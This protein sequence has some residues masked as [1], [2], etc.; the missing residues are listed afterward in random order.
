MDNN[1]KDRTIFETWRTSAELAQFVL[2]QEGLYNLDDWGG[3]ESIYG[4]LPEN[5]LENF[6]MIQPDLVDTIIK[7][8]NRPAASA[9]VNNLKDYV[10]FLLKELDAGKPLAYN[11]FAISVEIC[12]AMGIT[13]LCYEFICG[14][15]AA[16]YVNGCEEGIDRIEAEGYPD[17]LCSTQKGTAGFLL[18]G[19]IPKPDVLI[20]PMTP[21]DAS[22]MLYGW[23]SQKL[24]IPLIPIETPYYRDER[25]LKYLVDDIKRMIERLEKLTGNTLDEDKLREYVGYGNQTVDYFI[26]TQ[27]LKRITPCPDTGW[28]RPA[29][30][31]FLTNIGTPMSAAYFKE[32]Y[33]SVK[34]KADK[35]EGVIPEGKTEKRFVWGYT[36]EAYDLPFF[37]WL[38]EEHG[39]TY[40]ADCLTYF[41][42]DVGLIDT[43]NADS[44]IEGIAWRVMNMPMG[45]QSMGFSDT[46]INDFETV[47]R[48]HKADALI[49]GGHMACKH[50][51]ALNK[52][53]SDKIKE[54]TGIP[55]LRFE[56]DMFDKR[57]T[58]P[59][60]LKRIVGE[61]VT[62]TFP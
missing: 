59:A 30:T 4:I 18:M 17:H 5:M 33:E 50:F 26:K 43:S 7:E 60:E 28:H 21:C 54:K 29:D 47:V 58:P 13:P 36:W 40:M 2:G 19:V 39:V 23:T 20:K 45:R 61:F 56:M 10:D 9:F 51:W 38:E 57:F 1:N 46:W 44:M 37:D 3:R 8:K 48:S 52:L 34:A 14:L 6:D 15:T 35:G 25:S 27:E 42:P 32:L 53:M 11:Y 16:L 31:C 24:G 12:M 55:T 41:D 22:N 62:T 49:L